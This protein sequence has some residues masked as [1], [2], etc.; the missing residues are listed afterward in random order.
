MAVADHAHD[1]KT[2]DYCRGSFHGLEA[3]RRPDHTLECAVTTEISLTLM[4]VAV[5][6]LMAATTCWVEA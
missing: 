2:F 3:A 1:F 4:T 5:I 6:V